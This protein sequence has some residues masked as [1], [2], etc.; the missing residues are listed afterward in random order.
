MS[1]HYQGT[2]SPYVVVVTFPTKEEDEGVVTLGTQ[3]LGPWWLVILV[4]FGYPC[5]SIKI[6]IIF[7]PTMSRNVSMSHAISTYKVSFV[8]TSVR[9]I[10][11][12]S[13]MVIG[14]DMSGSSPT[15]FNF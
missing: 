12:I 9:A 7:N 14:I 15:T 3:V 6:M 11:P 4:P 2:T 5:H 13:T 1:N 8:C 10:R